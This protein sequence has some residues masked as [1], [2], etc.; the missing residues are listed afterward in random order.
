MTAETT[1]NV[2]L[3]E[4]PVVK[5]EE[6]GLWDY[7]VDFFTPD[8]TT[9]KKEE[10]K[11]FEKV[12][13]TEIKS[14]E[15]KAEIMKEHP[16]RAIPY[17]WAE[18]LAQMDRDGK[19][20][21][22][23]AYENFGANGRKAVSID[24]VI[25]GKASVYQTNCSDSV[26]DLTDHMIKNGYL[27]L[28]NEQKERFKIIRDKEVNAA[29]VTEFFL[30]N[31]EKHDGLKLSGDDAMNPNNYKPGMLIYFD[32]GYQNRRAMS[33]GEVV[34]HTAIVQEIESGGVK[35]LVVMNFSGSSKESENKIG[36][37][38]LTTMSLEDYLQDRGIKQGYQIKAVEMYPQIANNYE[39]QIEQAVMAK[40]EGNNELYHAMASNL[41]NY[42]M[43]ASNNVINYSSENTTD[44]MA[45][46]IQSIQGANDQQM[47]ASNDVQ[48]QAHASFKI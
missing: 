33:N 37:D 17:G 1:K 11:G 3:G 14:Q 43:I 29:S 5:V 26:V 20:G 22:S 34:G 46:K 39:K 2:E 31:A 24:D 48:M 10:N 32:S 9:N 45:N 15:I 6:K 13:I 38:A 44:L 18:S 16:Y 47:Y 25:S 12:D 41:D 30:D 19:I 28:S 40:M 36:S 8:E 4:P 21:Y 23:Q 27:E 7:I 35:Q 42:Q